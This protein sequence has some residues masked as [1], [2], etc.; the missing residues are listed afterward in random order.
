MKIQDDYYLNKEGDDFFN[1]NFEGKEVPELRENKI[2]ILKVLDDSNIKYKNVI[3]F[4]CNYGDLLNFLYVHKDCNCVG[5]EASNKAIN[6]GGELY[7]D[8]IQLHHGVIVDNPISNDKNNNE[9]FDLA[10]IDDVF[11][12][13]SRS[14]IL[15]SIAN[16]DKAVKD[17]GY[18]FIRDFKPHKFTKNRNHH[19]KDSEVFNFKV[20]GSHLQ[21]FLSTGMYEIVSENI[22]YDKSMSAGYL[23][24][25][26][27]NYRWSDVILQKKSTEYF[28]DVT[29]L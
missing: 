17:G 1:R 4:G 13:V 29:K 6:F 28:D 5:V 23:C 2:T 25:N 10:I 8:N 19:I 14:S 7:G 24:D 16:V 18:I 11:S 9:K 26:P 20:V 3:E 27:F 15:A 12:W 21:I 22:Y